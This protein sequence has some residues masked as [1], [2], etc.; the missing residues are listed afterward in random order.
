MEDKNKSGAEPKIYDV[1]EIHKVLPHRYPFLLVDKIV[2]LEVGKRA[3]GIK[4]VTANEEFFN[5]HFPGNPVMPGVLLVEAMAQVGGFALLKLPQAQG[6]LALFGSINNLRF[7][8][9]VLPGDTI[10]MEAE[11]TKI[12]GFSGKVN[13]KATVE[14]KMVAEGEYMFALIDTPKTSEEKALG[15]FVHPTASVH[16]SVQLGENVK[17]GPYAIISEGAAVGDNTIVDAHVVIDRWS[18]VGQ[19]CHIHYGAVIG[20]AG[21]MSGRRGENKSS[22]VIGDRNDIREYVT[23]HRG[24]NEG[25]A[26]VIGND[27]LFMTNVHIAHNCRIGDQVVI[28]NMCGLSGHAVVEDQVTI[29]GM[30]GV[31]QFVRIGRL[32]MIGGYSRVAQDIPP[33]MLIEGRPATVRGVNSVGMSRRGISPEAQAAIK[34]AYKILYRSNLN[35]SQAIERM[36]AELPHLPEVLHL[37]TFL[38][39]S[40]RGIPK[41]PAETIEAEDFIREESGLGSK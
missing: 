18:S 22:V 33:F 10:R 32:A 26:T 31:H 12:K 24:A 23:I 38:K 29:G 3:V 40:N 5:G 1:K 20:D 28:T 7:R 25:E 41:K 9:V 11:I 15:T 16:Y 37:T 14:G 2:E 13:V 36:Q 17:V 39:D 4:N 6:K 34:Q 8:R 30:V 19:N 35:V 21:Q 27:N